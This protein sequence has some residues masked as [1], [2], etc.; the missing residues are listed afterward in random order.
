[1]QISFVGSGNVAWHLAPALEVAGHQIVEVYSR[2]TRN[3]RRLVSKLYDTQVAPDLD[4]A[5][6]EAQLIILAIS[7]DAIEEVVSKMVFPENCILVHT[8]GTK[9]LDLLQKAVAIY[10][11]VP[12]KTG[13]FY[14]LQTFSK[15]T[16]IVFDNIPLCIESAD[17]DTQQKLVALAH[18]ISN[19]VYLVDSEERKVLHI[20]AVFACNFTNHLLAISKQI[21]DK[22]DLDF[23]LLKPLI[24]ETIRKA[25]AANDPVSVQ[26]G[27]ARRNDQ[28]TLDKHEDYL[29]TSPSWQ[30]LYR[31]LSESIIRLK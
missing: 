15:E 25:L 11:D 28:K 4:F 1:M 7:D 30:H 18:D 6:S 20:A 2:D 14:P 13:V 23:N 3:A 10:S 26:T 19:V 12:V 8:S 21:L 22:E 24:Q 9:S 27:P 17:F 16:A 31:I 5:E 29:Q